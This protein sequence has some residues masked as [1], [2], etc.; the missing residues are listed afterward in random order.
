MNRAQ[1]FDLIL[2]YTSHRRHENYINIIK[3]LGKTF[4]IGLLTFEPQHTWGDIESRY[5]EQCL[6]SGAALV[7]GEAQCHTLIIPRFG[8]SPGKGYFKKILEEMPRYITFTR[9]LIWPA[10]VLHGILNINAICSSLGNPIILTPTKCYFASIEPEIKEFLKHHPLEVVEVGLPYAKYPVFEDFSADYMVAYPSHVAVQDTCQHYR[11]LKKIVSVI[12]SLPKNAEI[13][14]KV[15]NVK[16]YGNRLSRVSAHKIPYWLI[17]SALLLGKIFDL[18]IMRRPL[19]RLLP[20]YVIQKLI[21]IHNEYIFKRCKNLLDRYPGF[22]IEHFIHGLKKGLITGLST[23]IIYAMFEK[24]PVCLCDSPQK[25]DI[26]ESYVVMDKMFA[27][28][29]WSGFS[30]L[31]YDAF[32]D[33]NRDADIIEYL[34]RTIEKREKVA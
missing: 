9:V 29:R 16:D 3:Y 8:G 28:S 20:D 5:V 27:M 26:P 7:Q 10:G 6:E 34:K 22:G 1:Y 13:V 25:K 33:A 14:V 23:S 12:K 11:L 30:E 17:K 24:K 15:H 2:V 19:Y 4:S 32:S 21:V 31:G 18:K